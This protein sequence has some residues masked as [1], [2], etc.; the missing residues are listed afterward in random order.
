MCAQRDDHGREQPRPHLDPGLRDWETTKV[1]FQLDTVPRLKA[2]SRILI[3]ELLSLS[4]YLHT[5]RS[6]HFT[7]TPFCLL[8]L[9]QRILP[10]LQMENPQLRDHSTMDPG[11]EPSGSYYKGSVLQLPHR[12]FPSAAGKSPFNSVRCRW[13]RKLVRPLRKNRAT[14]KPGHPTSGCSSEGSEVTVSER[15]LHSPVHSG[16]GL[17]TI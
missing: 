4:V 1:S 12:D 17:G 2:L 5:S 13:E 7:G 14:K 9:S 3:S 15:V 11:R 6:K 8:T 10:L 16:Q